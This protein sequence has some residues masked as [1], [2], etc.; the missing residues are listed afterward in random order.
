MTDTSRLQKN[1]MCLM[2]GMTMCGM[3]LCAEK[4]S[5]RK[6]SVWIV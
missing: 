4:I 5:D 2:C 1:M 3:V 6:N